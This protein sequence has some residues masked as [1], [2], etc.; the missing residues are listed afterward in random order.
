[1][2]L[3]RREL[4]TFSMLGC[5]RS[6]FVHL[7]DKAKSN[8][9]LVVLTADVGSWV[10]LEKF[11]KQCPEQFYNIGIAEQNMVGIAAGMTKTGLNVF[12]MTYAVFITARAF[13]QVRVNL[14]YMKYPIKLVGRSSGLF[15]SYLGATHYSWEDIAL[16][17]TIP[18]LTIVAPADALEAVK[19][20]EVA[21]NFDK[22]MYIRLND[23]VNVPMI[24]KEDYDFEIGR[25]I[26]LQEGAD[27]TIFATG[28]MVAPSLKAAKLL[29][30][31]NIS[32]AVVN[33]HTIKPLDI[34][35]VDNYSDGRKLIV[36]VEE[37][38]IIGGLGSAIAEHNSEKK[39]AP[40]QL[41]IGLPDAYC[42]PGKYEYL[43][44]KH[45]L[46]AEK[47]CARIKQK[48]IGGYDV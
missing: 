3:T 21:V 12:A 7:T 39:S 46:T 40:P 35:T 44:D 8:E 30:E 17:R 11:Q 16:M 28:T 29:A 26:V 27:V 2:E 6:F 24:Y 48:L 1:M 25:A 43:L 5:A 15:S 31:E 9:D 19:I 14:G 23:N 41:R 20:A 32:A 22:P 45:G 47:I 4:R 36:S 18:N 42:K 34:E 38:T 33:V 37:H 13:D 10:G